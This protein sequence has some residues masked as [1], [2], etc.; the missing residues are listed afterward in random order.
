MN[1][2]NRYKGM[3]TKDEYDKR[4]KKLQD[5]LRQEKDPEKYKMEKLEAGGPR[6]ACALIACFASSASHT[7]T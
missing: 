7:Y 4:K 6:G 2:G 1:D 3:L 5:K